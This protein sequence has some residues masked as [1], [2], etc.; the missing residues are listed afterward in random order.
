MER[1]DALD[2]ARQ[3]VSTRFPAA[4]AAF[5]TG[6]VLTAHR[7]STSDLD[8]VIVLEGP[9]APFRETL[10]EHGWPVELFVQTLESIKYFSELEAKDQSG[11][12][13]K[14]ISDGF[15]LHSVNGLA[16]QIQTDATKRLA[17]GPDSLSE[18]EMRRRRYLLTDQLDDLIGSTNPTEIMYITQQLLVG[19]SELALI[20]KKKW[21]SSGKWLA[22]T[23]ATTDPDFSDRLY[24]ATRSVLVDDDKEPMKAVT[25][26]I[27]KRVG[28]P[29]TEG[30]KVDGEILR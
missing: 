27:L 22:R 19:C 24:Q 17:K 5:L 25:R 11:V 12:T 29:L 10:R 6:S 15:I 23:L 3:I 14:M 9:P 20:S 18:H 16:E 28:G 4:R 1:L 8:I 7:T 30:Y 13:L 26:E 21:L 2:A